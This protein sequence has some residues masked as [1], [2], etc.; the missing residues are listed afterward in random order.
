MTTL[1]DAPDGAVENTDRELWRGPDDGCGDFYADSIHVTKNGGIGIN[2]GGHVIVKPLRAWHAL[3]RAAL[4]EPAQPA[5]QVPSEQD[6]QPTTTNYAQTLTTWAV[7][8]WRAEVE[9]RPLVNKHRRTLDDCWRHVIRFAGGNPDALIGP[10]HDAL[11]ADAQP[12]P[13]APTM[14]FV[15]VRG[16]FPSGIEVPLEVRGVYEL[17]GGKTGVFVHVPDDPRPAAQ[18]APADDAWD[19]NAER[20]TA[21]AGLGGGRINPNATSMDDIFLDDTQ[22]APAE[23]QENTVEMSPE[24]T[25]TSR[26]ALA[27]VLWHHQG[28]SSKVGQA[29]RFA[30]GMGQHD[31]L[32]EH[33]VAEAKRWG[34]SQHQQPR[35]RA[36]EQ[37][38]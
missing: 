26:A 20:L 27:W 7:S 32:T 31:P 25:D 18:P 10:S 33:Q 34:H 35:S 14:T 36:N 8:R 3:A 5:A 28:G 38:R 29:M 6:I 22:P 12:A 4:A 16:L 37:D 1:R 9:N 11:L 2:V 23:Q 17:R 15:E 13:A 24:F 19:K 21:D 30:L